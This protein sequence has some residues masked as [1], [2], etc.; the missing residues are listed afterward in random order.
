MYEDL[1]DDLLACELIPLTEYEWATRPKGDHGVFQI[2]FNPSSDNGDDLHQDTCREGSV[3]LYTRGNKPEIW[4]EIERI[5]EAH[6]E[7]AWEMNMQTVDSATRLLHR[8][9]VFQ[10]EA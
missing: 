2:D 5:L 3:D 8:E 9:Y 1:K 4:T 7:G 6:C 10:L